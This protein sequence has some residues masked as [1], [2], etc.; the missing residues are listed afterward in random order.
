MTDSLRERT[1][2]VVTSMLPERQIYIRSNGRVQFFTL[3]SFTQAIF[4]G[5]GVLFLGW[6]TFTSVNTIFKDR[7]LA[8]REENFRRIQASYEARLANLQISYDRVNGAFSAAQDRFTAIADDL[9]AKHRTLATLIGRRSSLRAA[10]GLSDQKSAL[11]TPAPAQPAQSAD[12]A[13]V[14][15]GVGGAPILTIPD[16]ASVLGPYLPAGTILSDEVVQPGAAP[17]DFIAPETR[18]GPIESAPQPERHSSAQ[19]NAFLGN[20]MNTFAAL[21]GRGSHQHDGDHPAAHA[22]QGL[23][24][25]LDRLYPEQRDLLVTADEQ[26]KADAKSFTET[27]RSAGVEPKRMV[28]RVARLR[29][30]SGSEALPISFIASDR[31]FGDRAVRTAASLE[32]FTNLATA[33]N[34]VPL[35]APVAGQEFDVASGFGNR[36]DPFTNNLAFHAGLDFSGPHGAPVKVTAPGVVTYSGPRG[37]YGQTVEVDHGY[38]MK[39]RYG[40]LSKILVKVGSNLERGAVVGK[41][42]STGRSTGPHVHYEIWFDDVVRNPSR[43]LRAGVNVLEN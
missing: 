41:L 23:V 25:R 30:S 15:G 32:E 42:G 11:A 37:A 8:A 35:E 21:F 3:S 38:G 13:L 18:V 4:A 29:G 40:H 24:D 43:F 28:E 17:E 1:R 27:L 5:V 36:K 33:L 31:E 2:T 22:I 34:A 26:I 20:A 12:A 9:E 14:S 16:S 39:T 10:L 7:I 19:P 6:V